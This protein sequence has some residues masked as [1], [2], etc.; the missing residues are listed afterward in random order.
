MIGKFIKA[1]CVEGP[2]ASWGM[3]YSKNAQPDRQRRQKNKLREK[4]ARVKLMLT[5]CDG[6][7]SDSAEIKS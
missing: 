4:A 1:F 5:G 2:D 3:F 6:V 7:L